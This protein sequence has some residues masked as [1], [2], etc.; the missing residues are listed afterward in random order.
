MNTQAF[1][2]FLTRSEQDRKGIFNR[3]AAKLGTIASYMCVVWPIPTA[4]S[5]SEPC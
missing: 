3:A 5:L 1:S 4:S 2:A